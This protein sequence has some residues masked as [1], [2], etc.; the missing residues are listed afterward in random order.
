MSFKIKFGG[1][2]GSN[3]QYGG[4]SGGKQLIIRSGNIID[5]I[6]IGSDSIG[7]AGGVDSVSETV[8]LQLPTD[9][10]ITLYTVVVS[11]VEQCKLFY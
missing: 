5:A 4:N 8:N 2:G 10:I 1:F 7:G 9:G 6:K 3:Q 11:A